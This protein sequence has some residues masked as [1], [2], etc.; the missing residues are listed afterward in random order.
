MPPVTVPRA[1]AGTEADPYRPALPDG[2]PSP[3]AVVHNDDG[4]YTLTMPADWADPRMVPGWRVRR[5]L[6][7]M[8][9]FDVI[10]A[11]LS[12]GGETEGDLLAILEEGPRSTPR[13]P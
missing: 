6:R 12:A 13:T 9:L 3:S 11:H 1:G 4:T 10:A 7:K 5:A 8:G 2:V